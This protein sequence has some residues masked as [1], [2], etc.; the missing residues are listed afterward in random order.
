MVRLRGIA[1]TEVGRLVVNVDF[2]DRNDTVAS[3]GE[4][5]TCHDFD[6]GVDIAMVNRRS[7][8]CLGGS[9]GEGSFSEITN[10]VADCDAIH[11]HPIKW[12]ER[13][14]CGDGFA[15]IAPVGFRERNALCAGARREVAVN[16]FRSFV[17]RDKMLH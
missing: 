13:S 11:H 10:A 14:V 5:A 15:E 3:V 1:V 16:D 8:G 6:A 2:F 9:D 4:D 17:D 7:S 12:G